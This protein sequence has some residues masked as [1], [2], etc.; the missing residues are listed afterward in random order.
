[1][2]RTLVALA[3]ICVFSVPFGAQAVTVSELQAQIQA[4][5]TTVSS[6]QVQLF[7]QTGGANTGV[8]AMPQPSFIGSVS[9]PRIFQSLSVGSRDV[10]TDGAVSQLQQ[11]LL[12]A[13][14]YPEAQI[15]GFYGQLT[16]RAVARLQ[17]QYG[18]SPV[19]SVGPQTQALLRK[20]CGYN[21]TP[22]PPVYNYLTVSS[23]RAGEVLTAGLGYT[24]SW[25]DARTYI[26]APRYD[27][28]LVG[29]GYPCVGTICPLTTNTS[30]PYLRQS[31]AQNVYGPYNWTVQDAGYGSLYTIQVCSAGG[32]DCA[33]SGTFSIGTSYTSNKPPVIHAFSGPTV[34]SVGQVGTWSIS[35]SDPEN[36][37][38]SYSIDWGDTYA[39]SANAYGAY[40]A[41]FNQ[42]STFTHSYSNV[43]TYTVSVTVSD[44]SGQ[45]ARSTTTVQVGGAVTACTLEYNPVC[46]QP[47]RSCPSGAF[48]ALYVPAPKTYGN[49]CQMNA[50]GAT[51]LYYGEC[52]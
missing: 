21:P 45:S 9:C 36:G 26:V 12:S 46:G 39:P 25:S 2:K 34:L 52:R 19:G 15:T 16:A 41:Y 29:A 33:N 48:C 3:L 23:P 35:A 22:V 17:A 7:F 20:L 31:I 51:L 38:L 42:Q 4:L 5:L 30:M 47:V 27:I 49:T 11:Y 44:S 43:G 18:I 8:Q 1:M 6:L 14:V 40:D 13:G 32:S 50:E 24:I 10:L 37:S 28:Y